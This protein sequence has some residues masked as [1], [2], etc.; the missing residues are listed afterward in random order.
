MNICIYTVHVFLYECITCKVNS[1]LSNYC[2]FHI[3][4]VTTKIQNSIH[5]KI[6]SMHPAETSDL[7]LY[8]HILST[9]IL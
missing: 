5:E 9:S 1:C 2:A 4:Y 3:S 7:V 8:D 6:A